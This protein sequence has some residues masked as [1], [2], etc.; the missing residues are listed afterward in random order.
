MKII[1]NDEYRWIRRW[2]CVKHHCLYYYKFNS[3][4]VP[5]NVIGLTKH[6]VYP[7]SKEKT[8]RA[9][10]FIIEYFTSS[11]KPVQ[12]AADTDNSS[13][14]WVYVLNKIE[15]QDSWLKTKIDHLKFPARSI[16]SSDCSGYLMK[17][18]MR[19]RSWVKRYC[20]LKDACL[21]FYDDADS[22]NAIGI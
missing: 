8:D 14:K 12:L 9:F 1:E 13:Q 3:D 10:S 2:F 16:P 4:L 5:L 15:T 11:L 6:K 22:K 19:W 18:G 17:L 21:Y 7:L 20:L